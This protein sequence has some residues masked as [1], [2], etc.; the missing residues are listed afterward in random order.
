MRPASLDTGMDPNIQG[1]RDHTPLAEAALAA[2]T[3]ITELLIKRGARLEIP[4]DQGFTALCVA[5]FK[6][7]DDIVRLLVNAGANLEAAGYAR[8][9]VDCQNTPLLRAAWFGHPSTAEFLIELGADI[10]AQDYFGRTALRHAVRHNHIECAKVL[11]Q[12]GANVN[13]QC[14]EGAIPLQSAA[15]MGSEEF[16]RLLIHAGANPRLRN[17]KGCTPWIVAKHHATD[18]KVEK[19]LGPNESEHERSKSSLRNTLLI[20]LLIWKPPSLHEPSSGPR[21]H[22]IM[23]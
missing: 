2:R 16:C 4:T 10:E 6:G 11:I 1:H 20:L 3:E 15:Q 9:H 7:A 14:N 18:R 12:R 21:S 22:L 19:V 17:W 8:K 5:A 13:A 23:I